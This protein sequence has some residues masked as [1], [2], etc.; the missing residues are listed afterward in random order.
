MKKYLCTLLAVFKGFPL[1]AQETIPGGGIEMADALRS[2][3]KIYVVVAVLVL[4]MT[5]LFLYLASLDRKI[6]K[7]EKEINRK[8]G[9]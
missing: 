4:I 7:F 1:L 8:K 6:R 2:S 9:L 3:G 5:G